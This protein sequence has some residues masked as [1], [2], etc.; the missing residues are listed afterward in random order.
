MHRGYPAKLIGVANLAMD[1]ITAGTGGLVPSES[2]VGDA[3][4]NCPP[5]IL[6]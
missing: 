1:I 3:S 6:S 4:A 5:K 2:G